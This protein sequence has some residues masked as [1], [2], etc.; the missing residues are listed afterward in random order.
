MVQFIFKMRK[1]IILL[2]I[3]LVLSLIGCTKK[4]ESVNY[5]DFAKCIAGKGI[6]VYGSELCSACRAE[7][8][9]FGPSWEFI[10]MIE[11]NPN[12]EGNKADECLEVGIEITPT[13]IMGDKRAEGFQL[14]DELA[15]FSGCE[16][17]T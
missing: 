11:C 17:P 9:I 15:E 10:G 4:D 6:K 2:M 16:L 3:V 12:F 13:F 1:I 14:M 7:K 5:D 8:K